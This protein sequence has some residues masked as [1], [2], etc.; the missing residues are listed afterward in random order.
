MSPRA[1]KLN[2]YQSHQNILEQ[3]Q[4]G[5]R[6]YIIF[7]GSLPPALRFDSFEVLFLKDVFCS[8]AS[9]DTQADGQM[10][11]KIDNWKA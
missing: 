11:Y 6:H 4:Q 9:F 7:E 3:R 10:D 5:S 1:T 8:S 2:G